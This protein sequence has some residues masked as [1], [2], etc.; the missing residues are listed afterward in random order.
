[1]NMENQTQ[2]C[3]KAVSQLENLTGSSLIGNNH[4]QREPGYPQVLRKL[5]IPQTHILQRGMVMGPVAAGP[6]FLI[7]YLLVV[8]G[9]KH[10]PLLLQKKNGG[11]SIILSRWFQGVSKTA[12]HPKHPAKSLVNG[13]WGDGCLALTSFESTTIQTVLAVIH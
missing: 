7:H 10:F 13:R 6:K 2:T 8:T 4:P 3:W 9:N 5:Q 11:T 12:K 1:M